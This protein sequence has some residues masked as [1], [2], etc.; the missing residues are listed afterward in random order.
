VLITL[1]K[2]NEN[3]VCIEISEDSTVSGFYLVNMVI[4]EEYALSKGGDA[5]LGYYRLMKSGT[6]QGT[7]TETKMAY[8]PKRSR[9]VRKI[10]IVIILILNAIRMN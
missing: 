4:N 7:F 8:K 5:C 3:E 2:I 6:F 10:M 9:P 1:A